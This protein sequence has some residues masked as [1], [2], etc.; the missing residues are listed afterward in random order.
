MVSLQRKMD[1]VQ[2]HIAATSGKTTNR[3][4]QPRSGSW[5]SGYGDELGPHR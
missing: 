4:W 3:P 2:H 5:H 1:G